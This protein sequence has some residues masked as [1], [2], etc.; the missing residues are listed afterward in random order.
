M[1]QPPAEARID[2]P[3]GHRAV[4]VG[5]AV[6]AGVAITIVAL[7]SL[8]YRGPGA[9]PWVVLVGTLVLEVALLGTALR[10]IAVTPGATRAMLFGPRRLATVPNFAWGAL[11]LAGSVAAGAVYIAIVSRI[12]ESLAP[13]PLPIDIPESGQRWLAL[14]VIVLVGPFAE[15]VFFR[16]FIFAGLL[17]RLGPTLAVVT[18]SAVFAVA[19]LD[20]AVAGPAFLS[21]CV[22]ALVY[23]RTGSLWPVV[24]AHTAQNA[25]A[26]ALAGV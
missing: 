17:R 8:A 22:F 5:L 4:S 12:S 11:A 13:S 2:V 10:A 14:F 16:G 1:L 26:F 15:E 9:P 19:H 23:R 7:L 25:I 21:G 3:W 20:L 24:L 18:S 6:A